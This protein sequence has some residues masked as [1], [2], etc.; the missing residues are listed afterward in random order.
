MATLHEQVK[1]WHEGERAI[2]TLLKVPTSSRENPTNVGLSWSHGDRVSASPLVAIGTVDE[3]GRPWTSIWGGERNFARQI[4]HDRLAMASLVDKCHDPVVKSLGLDRLADG[5]VGQT[6]G[7]KAISA[8]SIDLESRDRVKLAGKVVVG[9]LV[10]RP[11]DEAVS[12]VQLAFQVEES[13]GNCPKYLNKKV[14]WAHLPSPQLVSSSLPLPEEAI[15]LLAKA[16]LFF[17]S[18][19]NGQTMDT[20]HRGG[21]PGFMRVISNTDPSPGGDNGAVLIYPEYSGNRLYQTLGN[22]HTNPLIGLAIPDFDT[23]DVLYLTGTTELLVGDTAAAYLP[24]TKLA[25][26]NHTSALPFSSRMASLS[27]VHPVEFS[28]Y[29]PPLRKL[30]TEGPCSSVGLQT[31]RHSY[32]WQHITLDFGGELDNGW[33]HMNNSDPQSLNDDYVRTFTISNSPPSNAEQEIKFEITARKHGPVTGFLWGYHISPRAARLE[34]PVLGFGGEEN[35][36]LIGTG[37][38]KQKVFVAGGVGITPFLGQVR[39]IAATDHEVEL[40]WSL[41]ADD[42][43][44]A[45]DVLGRNEGIKQVKVRLFLTGGCGESGKAEMAKIKGLEGVKVEMRRLTK[46]DVQGDWFDKERKKYFL[47]AGVGMMKVLRG[48]LEGEEVVSESFEY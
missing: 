33:A 39:E 26:Q 32:S 23:S 10:G 40:I 15:S 31:S 19:T 20:N 38:E 14:I 18:S 11:N 44:F 3:Q 34:I 6:S 12:Q 24:H 7:D 29:N 16:D 21:P 47:C 43:P 30:T 45:R 35:F 28:P 1:G 22:L 5:E 9:A 36:R 4:S 46:K 41:R 8:L 13:L 42:L 2:H 48:W 27:E 17:L 37:K 25:S